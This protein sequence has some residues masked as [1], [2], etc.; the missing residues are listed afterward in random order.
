MPKFDFYGRPIKSSKAYSKATGQA[1]KA[2][3]S[4]TRTPKKKPTTKK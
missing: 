1:R 2:V 3:K 4:T